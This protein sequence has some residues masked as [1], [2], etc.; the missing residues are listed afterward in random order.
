M[1]PSNMK[2]DDWP[3]ASQTRGIKRLLIVK[4]SSIG[5]VAH[6]LPVIGL[7]RR[8][9]PDMFIGWVV[10]ERCAALLK[11][12]PAID[13]LYILPDKA[14]LS[15]LLALRRQLKRDRFDT[16]FDMQGLFLSGVVAAASGARCRVGLDRNREL[17]R[18]FLTDAV[19][20]GKDGSRHAVDVL[21][22]FCDYLGIRWSKRDVE[23]FSSADSFLARSEEEFASNSLAGFV[24]P[25]VALN[26][27]ASSVYK[28]WPSS[29][30]RELAA[31]LVESGASLLLLGGPCDRATAD[32][33]GQWV[34]AP[35]RVCNMA[36]KTSLDQL[37]ALLAKC[38]LLISGDTGPLHVGVAVGTPVV[39]LF[40]PTDPG[41]TGP[42]TAAS[43]VIWN[44]LDCGPC[45][46][47]PTCGGR[48]DCLNGIAPSRV[49][50]L[51]RR[52]VFGPQTAEIVG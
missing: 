49:L 43:D 29:H 12:N 25:I 14:A 5:D 27:G 10:K 6:A 42:Y 13:R 2:F 28:M 52:R 48:V 20:P 50:D 37:A 51:A 11:A 15:D 46:R 31:G 22:G 35:G 40:G 44:K 18:L 23:L 32:D 38:S 8:S 24:R 9:R 45:F 19:V 1:G 36:G 39:A 34:H 26:L 7:I 3:G 21:L 30:W 47:H 33:V 4:M 17:N 41:R 16:V